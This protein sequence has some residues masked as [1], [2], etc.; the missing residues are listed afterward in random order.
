[1]T[2]GIRALNTSP[3]KSIKRNIGVTDIPVKFGGITFVP[4]NYV[5]VDADG[6]LLSKQKL[7]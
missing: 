5:Y 2:I 4:D 1:M 3:V 6:M 7:L